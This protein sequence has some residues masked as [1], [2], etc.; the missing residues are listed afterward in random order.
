MY[1]R[2]LASDAAWDGRFYVG[3]VTTG[4][5]CRPS[6]RVRKPLRQ[7]V[8]FFATTAEARAAGL[9]P[10]RRC[11]PDDFANGEDVDRDEVMALVAEIEADP[12]RFPDVE[13]LVA[14]SGYGA[15]HLFELFRRVLGATPAS[16]LNAARIECAGRLLRETEETVLEVALAS[17]F[18]SASAFHRRFK[19]ATGL[20]PSAYRQAHS[21]R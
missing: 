13:A 2:L 5:Y 17:G 3:V 4:V 20:T 18:R 7:N 12:A 8:R 6:C 21:G 11:H 1:E 9:R 19:D 14:R 15:T 10:C 16:V